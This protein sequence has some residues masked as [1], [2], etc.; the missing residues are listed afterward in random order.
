MSNLSLHPF[1]HRTAIIIEFIDIRT[2]FSVHLTEF[3]VA[4][5][6]K[7]LNWAL[8]RSHVYVELEF[9]LLLSSNDD[10]YFIEYYDRTFN[11]QVSHSWSTSTRY[12]RNLYAALIY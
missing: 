6:Q 9:A 7:P 5:Y 12:Y 11:S 10:C 8:V 1:C 3:M 2:A 4:P